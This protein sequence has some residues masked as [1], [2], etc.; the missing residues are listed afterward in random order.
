MHP[1]FSVIF[2][3]VSS[4]AGFGLFALLYFT[5]V[6]KLGGG[7][8]GEQIAATGA[9]AFFFI[10]GGLLSSVL[11]LANPKNA[12]RAFS[13][14]RTSWLSR[15]GVFSVAFFP[16]AFGYLVLS[17]FSLANLEV[18][19]LGLGLV[20]TA[21]AWITVFSTGMIYGCLKTIR[22]WNT[23][24]VPANYL[25]LGNFSG[26]L[27]LL[28]VA[29]WAG[30]DLQPFAY[31]AGSMLIIA[32]LLKAIYYFWIAEPGAG[33]SIQTATGFTRAQVRLLD[34]G[35]THGTF[36]TQEFGFQLAREYALAL[37]FFVFAIGFIVPLGLLIITS[38][39]PSLTLSALIAGLALAGL[40]AERWLFFAEA[41]HVVNLYHGSQRC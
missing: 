16:V 13:R 33:P 38:G 21:L 4:G 31:L 27:M 8:S 12:W 34:A 36:L 29:A 22:Q 7:L 24:L 15:E 40:V 11:H 39:K 2:F 32:G 3:T 9:I 35:H 26:A 23:P 18:V 10:I 25:A 5:D 14:F 1:A 37:K 19:R 6:L 20:A 17:W 41:R 28:A 30:L